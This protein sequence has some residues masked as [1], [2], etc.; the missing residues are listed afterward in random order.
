MRHD[1]RNGL[2]GIVFTIA[3]SVAVSSESFGGI[4]LERCSRTESR[5]LL[6]LALGDSTGL[7]IGAKHGGYVTKLFLKMKHILPRARMI[8]LSSTGAAT[9]DILREQLGSDALNKAHPD[10]ITVGIG[11]DDL[12]HGVKINR[13][14]KNYDQIIA[15]LK[16]FSGVTIVV[17][18]IPDISLAPAVPG[19]MRDAARGHIIMFNERIAEIAARHGAI[20]IDLFQR[21]SE[22]SRHP[23]FFSRDGV[24]PSDAGYEFWAEVLWPVVSITIDKDHA[25]RLKPARP[26]LKERREIKPSRSPD[27]HHAV[28]R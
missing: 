18:N 13:F 16:Q 8:N 26:R 2:V 17:M 25:T 7:G 1:K 4:Q 22:F 5:S 28:P 14:A 15:R 20:L 6:Y 10:L 11:A 27:L 12:I 21:S 23:E 9:E 3:C 19:Y 24:H